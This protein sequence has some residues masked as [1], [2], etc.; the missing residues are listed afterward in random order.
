M[1]RVLTLLTLLFILFL[2]T[3]VAA[4]AHA[5][6]PGCGQ[7]RVLDYGSMAERLSSE[8]QEHRAAFSLVSPGSVY[9]MWTGP[10]Q[11]GRASYS[12]VL[13]MLVPTG[14]AACMVN[15]GFYP[16]APTHETV[17]I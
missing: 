8:H 7:H 14:K 1:P 17:G 2:L 6:A 16:V 9:E 3:A 13:V 15:A 12:L 10:V 11:D 4:S 5:S